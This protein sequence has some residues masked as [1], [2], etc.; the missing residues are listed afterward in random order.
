MHI[1]TGTKHHVHY[2]HM[3]AV[4]QLGEQV[5]NVLLGLHSLTECDSTSAFKKCGKSLLLV[6]SCW[7][8]ILDFVIVFSCWARI[9][10]CL[11][12]LWSW[13][14]DLFACTGHRLLWM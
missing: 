5:S 8:Q 1:Y 7:H 13:V 10:R 9:L 11:K 12:L 14:S 4:R 6:L 2:I 3:F